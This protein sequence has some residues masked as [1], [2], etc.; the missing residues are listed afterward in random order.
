MRRLTAYELRIG[1]TYA[2]PA[3]KVYMLDS[4]VVVYMTLLRAYAALLAWVSTKARPR[5]ILSE[6]PKSWG[7]II[8][9]IKGH[10]SWVLGDFF[11]G[12]R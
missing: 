2:L 6:V 11:F 8:Y 9:L 4:R 10:E 12:K 5:T 7:D 1:R 3:W